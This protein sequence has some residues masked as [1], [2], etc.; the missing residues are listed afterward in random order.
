MHCTCMHRVKNS[1]HTYGVKEI[2]RNSMWVACQFNV[3]QTFDPI[4]LKDRVFAKVRYAGERDEK[5]IQALPH[6][7]R[8][9][10]YLSVENDHLAV[11]RFKS[12]EA[13]VTVFQKGR[14]RNGTSIDTFDQRSCSRNLVH[15]ARRRAKVLTQR[16][17]HQIVE[18]SIAFCGKVSRRGFKERG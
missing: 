16:R 9:L 15:A 12:A 7:P 5:L 4:Y 8:G 3:F 18:R 2:L 17:A 13:K 1:I 11:E 6:V 10:I 14:R